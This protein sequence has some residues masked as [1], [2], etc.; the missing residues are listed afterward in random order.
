MVLARP[1]H[2]EG[3]PGNDDWSRSLG[4]PEVLTSSSSI[5][6]SSATMLRSLIQASSSFGNSFSTTL[7]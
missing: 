2:I 4:A 7:A 6:D 1:T 5:G 3:S